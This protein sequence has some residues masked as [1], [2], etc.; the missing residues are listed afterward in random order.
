M[1][2]NSRR[3]VTGLVLC[4]GALGALANTGTV[5][6]Q[7]FGDSGADRGRSKTGSVTFDVEGQTLKNI[8][9]YIQERTNVNIVLKSEAE[10]VKVSIKI[11]DLPWRDALDVVVEKAGCQLEERNAKLIVIDRPTPVTFDFDNADLR[12]VINTVADL[13][14]ANIVVGPEVQGSISV[15]LRDVPWRV[16]LD[17]IV[18]TLGYTVV[19][20]QRG[21]LRITDPANLQIDL[22]TRIIHLKYVRPQAPYRPKINL[23]IG[24]SNITVPGDSTSEI[25]ANFT[26]LRAFRATVAPNGG[27]EYLKSTNSLIATGTA[28]ALDNLDNLVAKLDTQPVQIYFDVKFIT[29]T[30]DDL[31]NM[32]VDFGA[33]GINASMSFG[34]M[35]HRLPFRLGKGGFED[36]LTPFRA[37]DGSRGLPLAVPGSGFSFGTLSLQGTQLQL[38]LVQTDTQS[39]IVQ[40]PKL[41]TLDN[42]EATI[43][44]GETIRFAR[45]SATSNQSGGL[46]FS[47]DEA[48]NSP[49]NVGFQLLIIPHVVPDTNQ[50][51]LTVMPQ[52]R[53][54]SGPDGDGFKRFTTGAGGTTGA[55]EILLP[56]EQS[57]EVITN[58]MLRD[59]QTAVIGG[60]TQESET[61]TENKIPYLGDIPLLGS[62]FKSDLHSELRS[63]LII[64]ITPHL[65]RTESEMTKLVMNELEDKS[66]RINAELLGIY[67]DAAEKLRPSTAPVSVGE[68]AKA[69]PMEGPK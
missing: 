29:T 30:N 46:E 25:E 11:Q 58:M 43:F 41:M 54:L 24:Q 14:G 17:T 12:V 52:Q 3:A 8:V 34:S 42:Q 37:A 63:H 67:G 61:A 38:N 2:W 65:V 26:L 53:S 36:E 40:A 13:S 4:V 23:S 28:P 60:L 6:A 32:G 10:E 49:V 47:I 16:A 56:Q 62:L 51:M 5:L 33:N 35:T 9:E 27:I 57:S 64:F 39:R 44:V 45:T 1:S 66:S 59:G 7:D 19:E 22:Q 69:P 55:Q 31:L 68:P 48:A 18:R 20:E 21:I 50:L 15:S